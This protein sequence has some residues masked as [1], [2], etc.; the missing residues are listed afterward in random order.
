MAE[1]IRWGILGTGK[2]AG[3]FAT[4]LG[5]VPGAEIRAV[6]SRSAETA[7]AFAEKFQ[8]P[9]AHPSYE[10]LA[11]D[12]EVDVI[13]VATPHALHLENCLMCLDAG[14]HVL[15]EK[16]FTINAVQAERVIA[17]ARIKKLFLMEAMWTRYI[18]LIVHLRHLLA[19]GVIGTVEMFTA[20][21]GMTPH[22]LPPTHYILQ[23]ELGGGILLDAGIYPLSLAS[24]IFHKQPD[25]IAGLA[26]FHRGVDVQDALTLEY[27]G[28]GMAT[29]HMTIKTQ[30][31][32]EF[33][34]YGSAGRIRVHPPLFRP[35]KLTLARTGE[36]DQEIE[37]PLAGNGWNYQAVEVGACLRAGKLESEVMPLD[38]TLALMQTLDRIRAMWNFKYPFE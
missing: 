19:E 18:P 4:G 7:R 38:E 9:H 25:R 34:I 2:I 8:I 12:A 37:M 20:G 30:I 29:M 31:P 21:L 15:C 17:A 1:N 27:E 23:A 22:H 16:P 10:A 3:S 35:T 24:M 6:G 33:A 5:F 13:Y 32:P 11:Q 36:P 26:E 28:G 14:K